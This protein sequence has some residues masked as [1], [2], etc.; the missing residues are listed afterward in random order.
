L[1]FVES[2]VF[3]ACAL[4][5][6]L[7]SWPCGDCAGG[8]ESFRIQWCLIEYLFAHVPHSWDC[9]VVFVVAVL[10]IWSE[11]LMGGYSRWR[12]LV[13]DPVWSTWNSAVRQSYFEFNSW[14][15][16]VVVFTSSPPCSVLI[17][18]LISGFHLW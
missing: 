11:S 12:V 14:C 18:V 10:Q 17:V 16:S 15:F 13:L 1:V 6:G 2:G 9:G 5:F 3:V 8:E 7:V 4:G